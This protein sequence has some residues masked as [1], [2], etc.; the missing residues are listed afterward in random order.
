MWLQLL[1]IALAYLVMTSYQERGDTPINRHK[2][3][4]WLIWVLV[5]QSALR[6]FGIGI[7][8]F[9][10]YRDFEYTRD[11][12]TWDIVWQN[13]YDVY[14]LG[15][16]KDAGY[17]LLMK[18]FSTV[19]PSF[20]VYLFCVA[21]CFFVPFYRLVEKKL[22]S[23]RQ[24]Y[25]SFCVYQVMFYSFFSITG[26]RQTIATIATFYCVKFIEERKLWKFVAVLVVA[27]FIHKSVF[28]FLPFYFILKYSNSRVVLL[29][30]LCSLPF[31]FGVARKLATFMVDIS[32]AETYRMYAESEMETSG[33]ANFL[34]FIVTAAVMT[35]IAKYRNPDKISDLL[36]CAMALAV[37]FTPMMWVDTSLMRVIQ[38][39]S[40][41]TVIAIPL[42][43]D[44]ISKNLV[45]RKLLYIAMFIIFLFT[46]IRHNYDYAFFWQEMQLE[47]QYL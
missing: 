11:F 12:R 46:I 3:V 4:T 10:Y 13:F 15:E 1:L 17:W 31:I 8:T 24:L 38:Y 42:S 37:F 43:V 6:H 29:G 39:Y 16:G 26:I 22:T 45:V 32:G 25:L 23:L 35:L 18:A 44:Y 2:Y 9:S 34:I 20:R 14:V 5:L 7:D 40:I 28:L 47:Q 41:F 19:C 21:I 27:S 36:A 33:A 30:S